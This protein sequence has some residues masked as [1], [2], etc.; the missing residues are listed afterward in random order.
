MK[1]TTPQRLLLCLLGVLVVLFTISEQTKPKKTP[2]DSNDYYVQRIQQAQAITRLL[3]RP[4]A[5]AEFKSTHEWAIVVPFHFKS[6]AS[7]LEHFFERFN[8]MPP[9]TA[10]DNVCRT[11]STIVFFVEDQTAK[12]ALQKWLARIYIDDGLPWKVLSANL[13]REEDE[14][15]YGP[16]QMFYRCMV[17]LSEYDYAVQVETDVDILRKGW[18]SRASWLAHE[19]ETILGPEGLWVLGGVDSTV[20]TTSDHFRRQLGEIYHAN[21]NV[22]YHVGSRQFQWLLQ[23][24]QRNPCPSEEFERDFYFCL[25]GFN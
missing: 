16:T 18:L 7:R 9:C 22:V 13:T 10:D 6:Q 11:H 12:K 14:Y 15:P 19:Y 2:K 23:L 17:K 4:E 20:L 3:P 5:L 1:T 24:A 21:G 8:T 25:L